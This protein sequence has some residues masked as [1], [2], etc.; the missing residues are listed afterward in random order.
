MSMPEPQ[1]RGVGLDRCPQRGG[2]GQWQQ[3]GQGL[4]LGWQHICRAGSSPRAIWLG[5]KVMLAS[6]WALSS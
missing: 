4:Q 6:N 1:P 2:P 3:V 5:L